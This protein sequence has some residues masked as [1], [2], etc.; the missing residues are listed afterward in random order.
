MLNCIQM[1][2]SPPCLIGWETHDEGDM[3]TNA[4]TSSWS[5]TGQ[6]AWVSTEEAARLVVNNNATDFTPETFDDIYEKVWNDQHAFAI[7]QGVGNG[8]GNAKGA[9]NGHGY[10]VNKDAKAC[11]F[12]KN[13]KQCKKDGLCDWDGT[14][15]SDM[16]SSLMEQVGNAVN[17]QPKSAAHQD[18]TKKISAIVTAGLIL[19]WLGTM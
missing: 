11:S 7:I 1:L 6:M 2:D 14:A 3:D 4:D 19:L 5:G 18:V 9:Q 17:I 16:T 10:C 12:K 13:K 8:E 15:C